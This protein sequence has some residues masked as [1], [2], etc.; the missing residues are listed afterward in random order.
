MARFHEL[1]V[2]E[3]RRETDECVSVRLLVPEALKAAFAYR[4]GQHLILRTRQGDEELRRTY[5]ICSAVNDPELRICVKAQPQG[6]FSGWINRELAVGARIEV[7]PPAG[8]FFVPLDAQAER[9]FVAFCAGSGITPIFSILR[10]TLEGEPKSRFI[11]IYGSRTTPS[12]IFREELED[13]KNRYLTRLSVYHIL[14]R[15]PQE[16]PL[17]DGR[18]DAEKVRAF[19]RNIAPPGSVAAWFLCGPAPMIGEV[20]RTLGELGVSPPTIHFEYFTPEGNE[21]RPRLGA[22]GVTPSTDDCRVA[23]Q[24]DGKRQEFGYRATMPSILD[25][26]RSVG[27]DAPYSCKAGVCSTCRAKVVEG[28]VEMRVNYALEPWEVEAGFVLTCQSVPA[29]P[30]VVVDYD[31]S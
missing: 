30:R 29:S 31:A 26:A 9:L 13:L 28:R 6:R 23:V 21:P 24:L 7:M 16:L 25:G 14:S 27:I 18:I 2:G 15:E 20:A 3:I 8:R 11:L 10:S 1:A 17:L 12:I 4:P 19:C 22:R 5:S